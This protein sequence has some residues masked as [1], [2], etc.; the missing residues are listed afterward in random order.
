MK[1]VYDSRSTSSSQELFEKVSSQSL[2]YRTFSGKMRVN[3]KTKKDDI[4]LSGSLKMVK[5][6]GLLLSFQFPFV[7]EVLRMNVTRDSI[8]IVDRM[9]KRFVVES[10][11]EAQDKTSFQF[12]LQTLQSLFANRFF[13][14]GKDAVS[15]VDFGSVEYINKEMLYRTRDA[16]LIN[17][18]FSVDNANHLQHT[19]LFGSEGVVN[20]DWMYTQ[21]EPLNARSQFPMQM[22]MNLNLPDHRLLLNFNFSKIDIDS[23]V[24]IDFV[25]PARYKRVTMSQV[26]TIL[27]GL[28]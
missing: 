7:G 11:R 17:Y 1:D 21:F 2:S 18:V 19:K 16:S 23:D 14:A 24:E 12:D 4:S 15:Y 27:N 25:V 20:M 22:E 5:D 10:I 28:R 13:I 26:M 3:L 8:L 6:S 9:N